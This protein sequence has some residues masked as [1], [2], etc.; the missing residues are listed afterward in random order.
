MSGW[1]VQMVVGL[2]S[3]LVFFECYLVVF[4]KVFEICG[5]MAFKDQHV[6]DKSD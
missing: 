4:I 5:I 2:V 6:K 3:R 1:G